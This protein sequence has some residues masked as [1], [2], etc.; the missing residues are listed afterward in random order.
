[1][2]CARGSLQ[3]DGVEAGYLDPGHRETPGQPTHGEMAHIRWQT[4]TPQLHKGLATQA[5]P[6]Q[7]SL[8]VATRTVER[9]LGALHGCEGAGERIL[10]LGPRASRLG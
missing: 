7:A 1:M 9:G 3:C 4:G 5:E 10:G 6:P 2:G 8:L